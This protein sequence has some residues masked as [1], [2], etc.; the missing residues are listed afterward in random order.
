M[1]GAM[2][3]AAMLAA[4]CNKDDDNKGG[5]KVPAS[6]TWTYYE[7]GEV[8]G[9]YQQVFTYDAKNRVTTLIYQELTESGAVEGEPNRY[10]FTYSGDNLVKVT[11]DDNDGIQEIAYLSA[12]Q[13]QVVT[14][15]SSSNDTALIELNDKGQVVKRYGNEYTYNA[16]GT[17]AKWASTTYPE[18]STYT[19]DDKNGIF[20]NCNMPS[21]WFMGNGDYY[22]NMVHNA[23]S[24]TYVS[25][26]GGSTTSNLYSFAMDVYDADG[27]PTQITETTQSG[28]TRGNKDV[29]TIVYK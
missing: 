5:G 17:I 3:C 1:L 27:Y 2:A 10:D 14:K 8:S 19:Y 15:W 16:N 13:V 29:M 26:Y 6:V 20:K 7:N 25:N 12:T 21:W 9:I 23:T 18:E 4:S 11:P 24:Y 22:M 28:I